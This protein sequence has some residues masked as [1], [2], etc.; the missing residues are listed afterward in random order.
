[1]P[2]IHIH[3]EK[4]AE[5]FCVPDTVLSSADT[6]IKESCSELDCRILGWACDGTWGRQLCPC[7]GDSQP[8]REPRHPNTGPARFLLCL[9]SSGNVWVTHEEMET[10][11]TST[12]T[13]SQALGPGSGV[14]TDDLHED[15]GKVIGRQRGLQLIQYKLGIPAV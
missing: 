6:V 15:E 4:F 10:L 2:F 5:Y 7:P 3:S 14:R 13:V 12:K 8:D 11:A 9:Q 1:M